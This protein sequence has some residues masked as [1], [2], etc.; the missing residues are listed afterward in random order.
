MHM[1]LKLLHLP[2][3]GVSSPG[4]SSSQPSSGSIGRSYGHGPIQ[5]SVPQSRLRFAYSCTTAAKAADALRHHALRMEMGMLVRLPS[6]QSLVFL[7][8][9]LFDCFWLLQMQAL[10]STM[11]AARMLLQS[12]QTPM[13]ALLAAF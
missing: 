2:L 12:F 6:Q 3:E 1:S 5:Q 13:H 9:L 10:P 7:S 8:S 11:A 4:M